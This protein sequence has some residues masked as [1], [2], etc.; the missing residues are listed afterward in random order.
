[1]VRVGGMTKKYYKETRGIKV[2]GGQRVK[3]GTVLTRQGHKWK[4]GLNI[5][6]QMHLTAR[7]D[8]EIYFTRKKGS[9]KKEVL[10][11]NVRP[12]SKETPKAKPKKK[13]E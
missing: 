7:C 3:A 1:M 6:G 4:P 13:A 8:G 9:Y 12:L 10:Y 2:S 11:I 5:V